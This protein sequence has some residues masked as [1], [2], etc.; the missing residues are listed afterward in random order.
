MA[1]S[2]DVVIF[3]FLLFCLF[4][5]LKLLFRGDSESSS[6]QKIFGGLVVLSGAL[7][8]QNPWAVSISIFIAGL[9]IASEDFM[10]FFAAIMRTS[11]DRVP[12]TIAAFNLKQTPQEKIIEKTEGEIQEINKLD[13]VISEIDQEREDFIEAKE[14]VELPSDQYEKILPEIEEK[15]L[16]K[17]GTSLNQKINRH[18]F[19]SGLDIRFDGGIINN[20]NKTLKLFE[21]KVFPKLP[22]NKHGKI[23]IF[24]IVES[25]KKTLFEIIPKLDLFLKDTSAKADW[26]HTF[27]VAVVLNTDTDFVRIKKRIE[28]LRDYFN[29]VTDNFKINFVFYNLK[30]ID[31]DV[32]EC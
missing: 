30:N 7:S 17:L 6:L 21:V 26:K 20:D 4:V 1:G 32:D 14:N 2:H 19:F 24:A 15:V 28:T 5:L 13:K 27:T 29:S 3:T 31:L 22:K 8:S 25:I 23:M 18:T 12:E 11:G 9:I 10:R 16:S